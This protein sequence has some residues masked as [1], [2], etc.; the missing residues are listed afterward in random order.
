MSLTEKQS[1]VLVT[2]FQLGYC[3]EPRMTNPEDLAKRLRVGSSTPINQRK[4]AE[5][6]VLRDLMGA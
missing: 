5:R 3:D 1:R 6:K 4:R 2:A